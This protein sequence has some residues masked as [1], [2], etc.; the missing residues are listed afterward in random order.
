MVYSAPIAL[1]IGHRPE[2]TE[3][4]LNA[5][6]QVRPQTLLIFANGS[7][8]PETEEKCQQTRELI[9]QING[10]TQVL[11]HLC[12]TYLDPAQKMATALD[13]IFSQ[14]EEVVIVEETCYPSLSF[15][16]FCERLLTDY[17]QDERITHINGIKGHQQPSVTETSYDFS[18]YPHYLGWATWKRVWQHYDSELKQWPHLYHQGLLKGLFA[19]PQ[20]QEYWTR[21]LKGRFQGDSKDGTLAWNLA[22]WSQHGLAITPSVD[23]VY[24]LETEEYPSFYPTVAQGS[25][26]F[27]RGGKLTLNHP[28]YVLANQTNDLQIAAQFL[29][30]DPGLDLYQQ[31][32]EKREELEHKHLAEKKEIIESQYHSIYS[33]TSE[34]TEQLQ[35]GQAIVEAIESSKFWKLRQR[36]IRLKEAILNSPLF[37]T[38]MSVRQQFKAN[39]RTIETPPHLSVVS[40][41]TGSS[42]VRLL[43]RMPAQKLIDDWKLHTQLDITEELKGH[44]EIYLYQCE[45]TKLNFF[46]PLDTVGSGNLY[47]QLDKFEWYYSDDKWEYSLALQD[48]S[49]C[50]NVL[51]VG[52]GF[53]FFIEKAQS[54]GIK[55]TG[56]ELNEHAVKV[57][58][59]KQ[60]PVKPLDLQNVAENAPESYDAVCSFQVLEHVSNP[61]DFIRWSVEVLKPGGKLILGVPNAHS[62]L[63]HQ[64]CLLDMP[65]HHM[66]QWSAETFK[67]LENLF[68]IKLI[69]VK[70]E[71]LADC[72]VTGYLTSYRDYWCSVSPLGKFVFSEP[73]MSY[74]ETILNQGLRKW[75]PGQTLYVEFKKIG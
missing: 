42:S 68:P 54:K 27:M 58:E 11:T 35:Q 18:L 3:K 17:G 74:Y 37:S 5:I 67:S 75:F 22:C 12:D 55:I 14:V 64:Y 7:P 25:A 15:F 19:D 16:A 9:Q 69:K 34:L 46:A 30:T 65:P 56:L 38:Q 50:N 48:L 8:S 23:L 10:E 32:Q 61:K 59:D 60:L 43:E 36:W 44:P 41:L 57:A 28:K 4:I 40:P 26:F 66:T 47:A 6:A 62:F 70:I 29:V 53:G 45:Q 73:A 33:K 49:G 31:L 63:K 13:W 72:H 39:A 21:Q 1:F 52:S 51:E 24:G 20:E 71:P 2:L